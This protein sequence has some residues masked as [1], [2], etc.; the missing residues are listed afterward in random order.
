MSEVT[1]H[2]AWR[3]AAE[4]FQASNFQPGDMV[5]FEWLYAH[6]QLE[7][8]GKSTAWGV[9][10]KVKLAFL[11]AFENFSEQ[12]SEDFQVELESVPGI[13]YR[14]VPPREQT[15][16]AEGEMYAGLRKTL[17]KAGRRTRNIDLEALSAAERVQN[18]DAQA[19]IA[20]FASMVRRRALPSAGRRDAARR[21]LP[22]ADAPEKEG[23]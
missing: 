7:L 10:E 4:D 19:K 9:V 21:A 15:S 20:A 13:G 23:A 12:L 3:Q 22:A 14:L 1:K 5:P 8:P 6:F 2:P 18:A 16:W 11:R 17:R